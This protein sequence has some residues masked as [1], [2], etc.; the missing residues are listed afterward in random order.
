MLY[1]NLTAGVDQAIKEIG[2]NVDQ[3]QLEAISQEQ[4]VIK[5]TEL[6]KQFIDGILKQ[7]RSMSEGGL[8]NRGKE[9][10]WAFFP[11]Q[12]M[13]SRRLN[14]SGAT[15]VIG[16]ILEQAGFKTEH[17]F[18][19]H[20]AVSVVELSDG[21][22][23]YVDSRRNRDNIVALGQ[24][25][26][27]IGN[28]T[29]R[30]LDH[31]RVA[32][33]K[34]IAVPRQWAEVEVIMGNYNSMRN[35]VKKHQVGNAAHQEAR[36]LIG[37]MDSGMSDVDFGLLWDK[38]FPEIL[39]LHTENTDWSEEEKTVEAKHNFSDQVENAV[40]E[41]FADLTQ[42]QRVVITNELTSN[43]QEILAFCQN[44]DYSAIS[45]LQG[46]LSPDAYRVAVIIRDSLESI[47]GQSQA[48]YEF[49]LEELKAKISQ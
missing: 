47:R 7:T 12:I 29:Y 32:Y 2:F 44:L 22:K 48:S 39:K 16:R 13:A 9:D 10:T 43:S 46:K 36:R 6:Q 18:A 14:C 42:D 4:D 37:E 28:L 31:P 23:Y 5:K 21:K 1:E 49:A 20:H 8:F 40:S 41:Q 26:R 35:E 19:A 24:E 33:R 38:M 30:E 45:D 11:K 25:E 15:L 3:Q 27:S 17:G 34:I